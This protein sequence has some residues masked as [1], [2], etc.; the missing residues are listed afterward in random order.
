M[1]K[2]A[3]EPGALDGA[4]RLDPTVSE[5]GPGRGEETKRRIATGPL[6][7]P[8]GDACTPPP[9]K[10]HRTMWL[11]VGACGLVVVYAVL[12]LLRVRSQ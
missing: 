8:R 10:V 12:T 3:D 2:G 6:A 5:S 9:N 4:G 11:M 7:G 1:F